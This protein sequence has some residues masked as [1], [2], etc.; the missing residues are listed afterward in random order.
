MKRRAFWLLSAAL[1]AL[2]GCAGSSQGQVTD[3]D[4]PEGAAVLSFHSF[5]GG[6]PEYGAVI[7]DPSVVSCSIAHEYSDPDHEMLD[8]AAFTVLLTFTGLKPG[9]TT[10]TVSARSPIADN[11]DSVY[12]AVVDEDLRVTLT[13]LSTRPVQEEAVRPTPVLVIEANDAVF[14]AVP[15]ENEAADALVEALSS[16]FLALELRDDGSTQKTGDLPW[17]LPADDAEITTEP[18]DVLLCGGEQLGISYGED[19][20]SLTRVARIDSVTGQELVAA[21]GDGDVT[22]ILWVEWSE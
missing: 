19:I 20:Q 6:G 10:V 17:T 18:G 13:E 5:D 12:S 7:E 22:V 3:V 9:E 2:T 14:Y 8:G 4:P 16:E 11:F 15:E 21:L 1:L